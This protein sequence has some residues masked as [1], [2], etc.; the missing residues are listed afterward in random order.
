MRAPAHVTRRRTIAAGLVAAAALAVA[1]CAP[2]PSAPAP[3]TT[4]TGTTKTVSNATLEWTISKEANNAAFAPGQ[5]NYW[6]AGKTDS[7]DAT[8]VATNGNATVLKKNAAGTYVPIGSEPAVS[9]ANKNKDGAGNTVTAANA[10]FL[11]QKIRYTNGTGTVD[12]ATGAATIQWTGTFSVNF[13]GIY[14][15]FW[16]INPKLTVN[17]GGAGRLTATVGGVASDMDDPSIKINVPDTP[18][19]V[20]AEFA[21]VY[22]GGNV[23]TGWTSGT[24]YLG[25]VIAPPSGQSP[26]VGGTFAGSWPQSFVNFHGITGTASYWYSS[27][28][29]VDANKPQ[30][31]VT[32][33]YTLNP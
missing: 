14:T 27:G 5:V 12:T 18:N 21:N 19:I 28:G 11:G 24:K 15:P 4:P 8:Y 10:F 25:T 29:A 30:D 26:Q 33:G 13:Y 2:E 7:T 1:A 32:V 3:T 6:S 16:I 31:P 23:N 20:L 17:P 9:W 22:S